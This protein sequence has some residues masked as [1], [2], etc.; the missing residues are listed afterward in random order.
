MSVELARGASGLAGLRPASLA[1]GGRR[2]D[3][4]INLALYQVGWFA[5]VLGAATG[6]AWQGAAVGLALAAVHL[7]LVP[8]RRRELSLMLAAAAIGL[9]VDSLQL[10]LGVFRYPSGAW[11]LGLA[12]AWILVLWL[13]FA[14]LFHF[15]LSWLGG[16]YRLAAVLGFLG[17]PLSF[18]SGAR[19]GAIEFT[20]PWSYLALGCVWAI[21]LPLLVALA[22]RLAPRRRGYR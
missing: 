1:A 14:T 2:R 9:A 6:L 5:C 18:A 15:A 3:L 17:G 7:L 22:D 4:V 20:S 11:L 13:Q 10:R 16:R 19:L 12:P 21:V 8:D